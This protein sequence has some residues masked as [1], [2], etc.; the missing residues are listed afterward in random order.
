MANSANNRRI[1]LYPRKRRERGAAVVSFR[2]GQR[3]RKNERTKISKKEEEEE[4]DR[5][6]EKKTPKITCETFGKK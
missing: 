6:R 3:E 5:E 2:I 4:E 1:S